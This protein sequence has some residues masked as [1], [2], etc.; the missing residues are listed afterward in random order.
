MALQLGRKLMVDHVWETNVQ[1][2]RDV[3]SYPA[4]EKPNILD[5]FR[6]P[7]C[8][9]E[10]TDIFSLLAQ[11]PELVKI[12][13]IFKS[14]IVSGICWKGHKELLFKVIEKLH[15]TS[16]DIRGEKGTSQYSVELVHCVMLFY[17]SPKEGQN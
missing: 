5:L 7:G 14:Q 9:A 4:A 1:L 13:T 3:A 12:M 11:D 8:D 17:L 2:L 10:R 6:G 15:I 16:K